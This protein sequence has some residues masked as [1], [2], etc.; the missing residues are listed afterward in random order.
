[1]GRVP[2]DLN[3]DTVRLYIL[4]MGQKP[5]FS[6]IRNNKFTFK[7]TIGDRH[8][9]AGIWVFKDNRNIGFANIVLEPG[10]NQFVST[11]TLPGDKLF[12]NCISR[13]VMLNSQANKIQKQ[14]DE[15][16][17]DISVRKDKSAA[18]KKGHA[19]IQEQFK[20]LTRYPDDPYSV[21]K[22]TELSLPLFKNGEKDLPLKTFNLFSEAQK[23]SGP[24]KN[25][26]RLS[27]SLIKSYLASKSGNPVPEFTVM[28]DKGKQF[29]NRAL[30]GQ[31]YVIAFSATWC[32][33]CQEI[34]KKLLALFHKYRGRGLKVIYFNLDD[35]TVKW[36]DHIKKNKLD[37]INVSERT[38]ISDSKIAP[39]FN[40]QAIPFYLVIDKNGRIIYNPDELKDD[41]YNLLESKI[42]VALLSDKNRIE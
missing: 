12:K 32:L 7:G 29:S 23:Q 33:P 6:T 8:Q 5:I 18:D 3:G 26:M 39:I 9:L 34:Q 10:L 13:W 1:M 30:I 28:I 24:G 14:L 11:P 16:S 25:F 17:Y 21:F 40:V 31:P 4:P 27:N 41:N 42:E 38:K 22:L 2:V 19:I 37:W 15:I 36:K 35:D 20:L